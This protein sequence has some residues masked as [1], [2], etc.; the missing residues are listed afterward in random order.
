MFRL[1]VALALSACTADAAGG[2]VDGAAV[3]ARA[4]ATCHGPRGRPDAGMVARL[5]V[6]DLTAPEFRAR[7]TRAL[8]MQQV[9]KGSDNKL[10]PSFAGT[11]S[12]RQM[13]AVAAYVAAG[14]QP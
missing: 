7:A 12:E 14:L 3:F 8:V 2:A 9:R 10:M 4:C 1:L 6:R 13:A 11:L 5:G